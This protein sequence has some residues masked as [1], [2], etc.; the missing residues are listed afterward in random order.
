MLKNPQ[1]QWKYI[2]R[3][4]FSIKKESS[5]FNTFAY[6]APDAPG[7]FLQGQYADEI[8]YR[9]RDGTAGLTPDDLP[10]EQWQSHHVAGMNEQEANNAAWKE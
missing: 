6:R 7:G 8:Y 1:S 10:G 4:C 9:A 5:G 3:S 2:F